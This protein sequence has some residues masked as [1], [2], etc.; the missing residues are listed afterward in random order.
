MA[1]KH[2]N[3]WMLAALVLAAALIFTPGCL[4]SKKEL[5][6]EEA[7]NKS[8]EYIN[9]NLVQPGTKASAV[10]VE[11]AGSVYRVTT[12]YMGRQIP[13]YVSKDGTYLFLSAINMSEEIPA[14]TP[15]PTP[16]PTPPTP[17]PNPNIK[18]EDLKQFVSCLNSS[19]LKIYGTTWCGYCQQLVAM[20]GGYEVVK[21]IFIDCDKQKE[22][23][24]N[25]NIKAYPTILL[26]G[27]YY[28][29]DRTFADL[30]KATGCS[31]P[32]GA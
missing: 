15:T 25:A 11:D 4:T 30:S 18:A 9:N 21:P 22:E 8:I 32:P 5:T 2:F 6:A 23:C 16:T 24:A 1:D 10:S 17:T 3:T 28:T 13:I 31:V 14:G 27:T 7:K 12:S 26:N 20:L 29:G 19:G